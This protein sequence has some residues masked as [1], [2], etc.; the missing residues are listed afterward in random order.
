MNPQPESPMHE[1]IEALSALQWGFTQRGWRHKISCLLGK[2]SAL[3]LEQVY[4]NTRAQTLKLINSSTEH[5]QAFKNLFDQRSENGL[6]YPT[7][8]IAL[9]IR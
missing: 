2:K 6:D 9:R 8:I 7:L 3:D 1:L 5:R 4:K